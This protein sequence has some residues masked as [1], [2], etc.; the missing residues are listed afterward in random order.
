MQ[1]HFIQ[2]KLSQAILL[3]SFITVSHSVISQP[4]VGGPACVLSGAEYQYNIS[5][6]IPPGSRLCITGGKISGT[7]STCI[8]HLNAGYVKVTWSGDSGRIV[9]STPAGNFSSSIVITS[10]LQGGAINSTSKL[11]SIDYNTSPLMISCGMPTGGGCIA[12]YIFQ[13]QQSADKLNWGDINGT[14][15]Q[16]LTG[17][18]A[19]TQAVFYRR[20]T[21]E[22]NSGSIVYS[23]EAVVYVSA[24]TKGH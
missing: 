20:K 2:Q 17:I 10:A 4:Y 18:P 9:L 13:W 11:Q 12:R 19:L 7:D 16:H 23:D 24:D 15:G 3:T 22:V 14:T 5:G 1:K 8:S 6:N 21:T